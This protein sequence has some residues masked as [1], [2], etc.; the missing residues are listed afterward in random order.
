MKYFL[1]KENG[2]YADEFD[3]EAMQLFEAETKEEIAD[4]LLSD[5]MECD[6]DEEDCE[7]EWPKEFYFGT[8]EAA[9]FEDKEDFLS[10]LDIKEISKE[11]YKTLER[12]LGTSF[13]VG[14]IL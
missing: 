12:L 2:N 13:G 3:L 11:E 4:S 9:T 1:V 7:E 14:A 8:N 6:E 5:H 10:S